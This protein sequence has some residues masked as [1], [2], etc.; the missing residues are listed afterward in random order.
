MRNFFLTIGIDRLSFLEFIGVCEY[1]LIPNA[2]TI[3]IFKERLKFYLTKL[4]I[5]SRKI[6]I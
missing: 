4:I 2:R 5:I 6:N 1:D 3:W